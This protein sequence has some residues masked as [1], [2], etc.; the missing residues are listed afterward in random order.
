MNRSAA[1]AFMLTAAAVLLCAL[2]GCT[3]VEVSKPDGTR[4]RYINTIFDKKVGRLVIPTQ[5]GPAELEQL[6][7]RQDVTNTINEAIRRIPVPSS[8][9]PAAP[10]PAPEYDPAQESAWAERWRAARGG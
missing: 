10:D 7:S 6:D 9:P 2:C 5:Y 8:A 4:Y 1:I 3:S